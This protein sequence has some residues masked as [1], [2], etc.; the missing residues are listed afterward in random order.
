MESDES[1][2]RETLAVGTSMF[3]DTTIMVVRN[4]TEAYGVKVSVLVS[5][6]EVR[7]E[8]GPIGPVT[9]NGYIN[10]AIFNNKE[11]YFKVMSILEDAERATTTVLE[12]FSAVGPRADG[13]NQLH[14]KIDR[15]LLTS[16][17]FSLERGGF[18]FAGNIPF[19]AAS[20]SLEYHSI[21]SPIP[22]E[23]PPAN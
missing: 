19:I 7:D 23:L 8:K 13:K 5:A 16:R 2:T 14:V 12:F 10:E 22:L 4:S 17:G 21:E 1:P 15:P 6:T 20:V 18:V 9:V 11:E 3:L